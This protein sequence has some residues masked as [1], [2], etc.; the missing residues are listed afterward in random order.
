MNKLTFF[1]SLILL[2]LSC[3]KCRDP[4]CTDPTNPDCPNYVEV[5]DPCAGQSEVN[6]DFKIEMD[7][8]LEGTPVWYETNQC[9]S[10]HNDVRVSANWE[11]ATSYKWILGVDTFYTQQHIFG[12]ATIYNDQSLPI[13]LIV[14]STP[15][16][17]CFP[18]DNGLDTIVKYIDVRGSCDSDIWGT[19]YGAWD[20]APLDSFEVKI[21]LSVCYNPNGPIHQLVNIDQLGDSCGDAIFQVANNFVRFATSNNNCSSA[22]GTAEL[23]LASNKIFMEY[24]LFDPAHPFDIDLWPLHKYRGRKISGQ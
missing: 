1:F 4:E 6:A 17:E 7:I 10:F 8:S 24:R 19:Y 9:I 12:V 22:R 2:V 3:S 16:S 20:E 21:L 14:E 18:N 23:D 13:K 15:N 11:N 5:V